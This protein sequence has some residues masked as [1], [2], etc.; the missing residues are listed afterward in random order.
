[1]AGRERDYDDWFDEPIPPPD[2]R[3]RTPLDEPDEE[4]WTVPSD[5]ERAPTRERRSAREPIVIGG[6]ELT[7]TQLVIAAIAALAIILAILAA[8]G[9]FSSSSPK[10][11]APPVT[12][13]TTITTPTTPTTTATHTTPAAPAVAVPTTALKPGDTGT[14]VTQL[15]RALNYLGYSVGTADGSYG[16]AT[17]TAVK[18]FQTDHNLTADGVAGPQTLAAM[19]TAVTSKSG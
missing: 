17:E 7:T 6:R 13:P 9:V 2:P 11:T 3:R 8:A 12:T 14:Q 10:A 16:P 19:K 15:Q 4:S 18:S 1:M 5:Y